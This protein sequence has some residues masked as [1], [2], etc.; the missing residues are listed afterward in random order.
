MQLG[1]AL[2]LAVQTVLQWSMQEEA[3]TLSAPSDLQHAAAAPKEK[4]ENG[5]IVK[6]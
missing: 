3:N 2:A 1:A 6:Q 4:E 5:E